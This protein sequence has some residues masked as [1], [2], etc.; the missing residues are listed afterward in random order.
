MFDIFDSNSKG[1]LVRLM[2][3]DVEVEG[4]VVEIEGTVVE[5]ETEVVSAIDAGIDWKDYNNGVHTE[6]TQWEA[7]KLERKLHLMYNIYV[8]RKSITAQLRSRKSR[9]WSVKSGG[10]SIK[11]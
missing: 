5:V 2:E 4:M 11:D 10:K 1:W 8:T 9:D 6:N 3:V 7:R